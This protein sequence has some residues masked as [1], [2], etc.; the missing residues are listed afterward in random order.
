M[1][2]AKRIHGESYFADNTVEYSTWLAMRQRCSNPNAAGYEYYGGRGIRVCERWDDFRLFLSDM[3]R[4]PGPTWSIDR[5]NVDGD[6]EPSNCR[7][8]TPSQQA[9][10]KRPRKP[11]QGNA[12]TP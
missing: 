5:I 12:V 2:R 1:G 10:N 3:G 6:Y 7:W 11:S 9:Q 8:A 4:K